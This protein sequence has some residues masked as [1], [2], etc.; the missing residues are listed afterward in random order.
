VYLCSFPVSIDPHGVS[1]KTVQ[2]GFDFGD[3]LNKEL[4]KERDSI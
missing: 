2:F 3:A 4:A 1:R